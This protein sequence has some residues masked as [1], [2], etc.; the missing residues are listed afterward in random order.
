MAAPVTSKGSLSCAHGGTMSLQAASKL[1]L[2]GDPVQAFSPGGYSG[3]YDKCTYPENSGG[4]CAQTT[5]VPPAGN[6][7][8]ATKLTVGGSPALLS[9]L[10]A[11]TM[12]AGTPLQAVAPGQAKLTA[13]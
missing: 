4:P 2:N 12:P 6:P 11:N 7:G 9:Q 5:P 1:T 3:S 8:S 10:T 13:S